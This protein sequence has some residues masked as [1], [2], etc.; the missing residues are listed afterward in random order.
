MAGIVEAPIPSPRTTSANASTGYGM[1]LPA[2]ANGSVPTTI[3][4]RAPSTT[5]PA[6]MRSVIRPANG[7]IIATPIPCGTIISPASSG[8]RPRA[9][10]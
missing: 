2:N 4:A 6:P 3:I 7:I 8:D 10:W 5:G 9:P 1:E